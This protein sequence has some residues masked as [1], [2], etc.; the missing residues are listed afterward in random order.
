MTMVNSKS[1]IVNKNDPFIFPFQDIV[2]LVLIFGLF[3]HAYSYATIPVNA[4]QEHF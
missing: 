4:D 3:A 2:Y 1:K